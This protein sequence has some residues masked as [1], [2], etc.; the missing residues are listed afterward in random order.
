MSV[1]FLLMAALGQVLFGFG[2]EEKK[3]RK[4]RRR[5]ESFSDTGDVIQENFEKVLKSFEN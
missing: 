2:G 1:G 3:K 5:E 4:R